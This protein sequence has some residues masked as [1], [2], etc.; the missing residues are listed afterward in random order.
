M[1][2]SYF[3]LKRH[4]SVVKFGGHV[5]LQIGIIIPVVLS[6]VDD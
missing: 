1:D 2:A 5:L 4:K 3:R 6:I